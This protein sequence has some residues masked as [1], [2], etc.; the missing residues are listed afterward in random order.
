VNP[1]YIYFGKPVLILI[2]FLLI[3]T[4][5][6]LVPDVV[7]AQEKYLARN[8]WVENYTK[9]QGLPENIIIDIVQDRKGFMWMTT[10]FN[11]VRFD[12]YEFKV[13]AP[14]EQYPD[15]YIH[16]GP[17]LIEDSRGII[18]MSSFHAGL[19]SFDPRS[20][21]FTRYHKGNGPLSISDD[22]INCIQEDDRG[23][24]WA[25][26]NNGLNCISF[27]ESGISV[28]QYIKNL[29]GITSRRFNW[30]V[31]HNKA[32]VSLI[33][34]GNLETRQEFI[35]VKD[36][37]RFFVVSMG[38]FAGLDMDDFGWI[39]NDHGKTVWK[40]NGLKSIPA[41]GAFKNK[42][43]FEVVQLPPGKY[44]VAY[45]TDENHAWNSWNSPP[46]DRPELW[47]I[48]LFSLSGAL[49]D[50]VNR[51]I[52]DQQENCPLSSD[53]VISI[54][55]DSDNIFWTL[56]FLGLE[57]LHLPNQ[58]ESR[59]TKEKTELPTDFTPGYNLIKSGPG[60]LLI[61]GYT[62][63]S[64]TKAKELAFLNFDYRHNSS[65]IVRL[66]DSTNRNLYRTTG[67]SLVKDKNGVIWFGTFNHEGNGL[68]I[69]REGMES[70]TF[71]RLDLAPPKI[72]ESGKPS[73]SQIWSIYE[74]RAGYVWVG[75][76]DLGLYKIKS[77]SSPVSFIPLPGKAINHSDDAQIAQDSAGNVWL[78][79]M[80]K[81]LYRY[82]PQNKQISFVEGSGKDSIRKIFY[83]QKRKVLIVAGKKGSQAY[84]P[85]RSA[86]EKLPM[87]IPDSLLAIKTDGFGNYW[88]INPTAADPHKHFYF[89]NGTKFQVAPFDSSGDYQGRFE[90]IYFGHEGRIWLA[91][92]FEGLHCYRFDNDQKKLTFVKKYLSKGYE[93]NSIYEDVRGI[94]WLGTYNNGLIRLDPASGKFVS[95][96]S[97]Q[98][99]P[100]NYVQKIVPVDKELWVCTDLGSIFFNPET[101]EIRKNQELDG[102]IYQEET[103]HFSDKGFDAKTLA[104]P[105][106]EILLVAENGL[107]AFRPGDVLTD[108]ST[109][110]LHV[111]GLAIGKTPVVF[112]DAKDSLLNFSHDQNDL[113]IEY[114]GIHYDHALL[115]Q[116][117]YLLKGAN[118]SWVSAG[119]ERVARF[120]HLSPGAYTF[121]LKSANA[122]GVWSE[123]Q[124]MF[125]F[126]IRPPW[127]QT[128]WAYSLYVL[129]F[130]I[131]VW[132]F[133][134][135]RSLYLKRENALLETKVTLR[136][137]ELHES[138]EELKATQSQ[139]IQ[140]EKMASLGELTAGIAHE[141]QNPLN[142]VNNFSE[143][144]RELIE[145]MQQEMD[146]GNLVDAKAISDD[147][148]ENEVK[149]SHHGKRADAI[150]KGML[151]HS[152]SSS[153]VKEPTDINA[154]ADEYLRLAYHGFRAKEKEF[155]VALR[156]DFD[157][158]IGTIGVMPQD[159]SR[160]LLNIFNNAFY[161]VNEKNKSVTTGYEPTVS[162]TTIKT[163]KN[164]TISI[165]DNGNGI[166]QKVVDK[167]FQPFFTSKPTGQGTG[168]GLSLSYDIIKAHG[169]EIKVETKPGE[170]AEFII[171]LPA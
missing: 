62:L 167:I 155:N 31:D 108:S 165:K 68:Y 65:R 86:F 160:V 30:I 69:A 78:N 71:G 23:N 115:N 17:G 19:F 20:E 43:E 104:T 39:E 142:F 145:E 112:D 89:F 13:F 48:Q 148:K 7:T 79:E 11:L 138:M 169:G 2:S 99:L 60:Q 50:S 109:P 106:G 21:K 49:N 72:R 134:W 127:W 123:P 153:G 34:V 6:A 170:S 126:V 76:R 136:T 45:K 90:H 125:A 52:Q 118:E 57:K 53:F 25:G 51:L 101:G 42:L 164:I 61:A 143:V 38:E 77:K 88:A 10:P 22:Y 163:D 1:R 14:R 122:S 47:G 54:L 132:S 124:K 128:W 40:Q 26:T 12:G 114:I 64:A 56:T 75:S 85:E 44:K 91:P 97:K 157:K 139:L 103:G 158:S 131:A 74:D 93:V 105:I 168:L 133:V 140:S 96:A 100:S 113:N 66:R 144:N 83:D 116:Y 36:T 16:F 28:K 32:L 35:N 81:G 111:T 8:Y 95:F 41:G 121:Y 67:Q 59:L 146:K 120:S 161:S 137:T 150:V 27:G 130:G 147:I 84:D 166:P 149:I 24:I 29:T 37:S 46:P 129:L 92:A 162:V 159:I 73:F 87:I 94:V 154:M 58:A 5:I 9:K 152:R 119:T 117:A 151:Q 135:Y 107:Y 63:D 82:T 171:Q 70:S 156:T 55:K 141:I 98:G 110:V 80:G 4:C 15:L 18:W 102:C 33:R 3:T